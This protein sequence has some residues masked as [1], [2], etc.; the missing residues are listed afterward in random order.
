[1]NFIQFVEINFSCERCGEEYSASLMFEVNLDCEDVD[2]LRRKTFESSNY[3]LKLDKLYA[4]SLT[5]YCFDCR[6][7]LLIMELEVG[8]KELV[9]LTKEEYIS[10]FLR[11]CTNVLSI[12]EMQVYKN[13]R[14]ELLKQNPLMTS[15][16]FYGIDIVWHKQ[17][18]YEK[19]NTSSPKINSYL[20]DAI[21][22]GLKENGWD[23]L[24]I[25]GLRIYLTQT[26]KVI[27][28]DNFGN[29]IAETVA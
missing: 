23:S 22:K 18:L 13:K 8:Y 9:E 11:G 27:V 24:S 16:P 29:K 28:E 25:D 15:S 10:V 2:E 17:K 5:R 21:Q 26:S 14:I 3:G 7:K 6:R 19:E 20:C 4:A 12:Q 1:M